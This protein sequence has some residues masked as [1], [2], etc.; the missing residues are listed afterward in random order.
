MGGKKN[1]K[2]NNENEF[3]TETKSLH[4]SATQRNKK[5]SS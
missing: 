5:I 1:N 3:T 2:K 4:A